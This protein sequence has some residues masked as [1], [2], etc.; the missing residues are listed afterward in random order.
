MLNNKKVVFSSI[1][2][3]LSIIVLGLIFES[4]EE[5]SKGNTELSV[6]NEGSVDIGNTF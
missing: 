3:F 4:P 2:Y 6:I 5:V 1:E